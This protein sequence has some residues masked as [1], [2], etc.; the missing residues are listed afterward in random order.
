MG[1]LKKLFGLEKKEEKQVEVIEEVKKPAHDEY[2][3][4]KKIIKIKCQYC[5]HKKARRKNDGTIVCRRCKSI[6]GRQT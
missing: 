5:K 1:F 2:E 6:I 3:V 4:N